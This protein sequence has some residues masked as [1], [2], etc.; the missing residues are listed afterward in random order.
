MKEAEQ[1]KTDKEVIDCI[2]VKR[3]IHL[4]QLDFPFLEQKYLARKL[5]RSNTAISFALS[6]KRPNLLS[7]INR[8]LNYLQN[9]KGHN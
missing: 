3:R 4:M 8:H 1:E 5:R 7:R 9:K 6:G 2:S